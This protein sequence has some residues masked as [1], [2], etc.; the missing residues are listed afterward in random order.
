MNDE[1]PIEKLL[2]R[3]AKKRSDEAGPPPELHPATRRL[4]QGEVARQFPKSAPTKWS[5]LLE[6]WLL[7][8]QR[9]VYGVVAFAVVWVAAVALVPMFSKSKPQASLALNS[10]AS[11]R[12]DLELAK[13]SPPASE[14][15]A[16]PLVALDAERGRVRT[17]S[18]GGAV[19]NVSA[20]ATASPAPAAAT[21]LADWKI[22]T[23]IRRDTKDASVTF[24]DA[25]DASGVGRA[26]TQVANKPGATL[27]GEIS[28]G[29]S[30][31]TPA[32]AALGAQPTRY[33]ESDKLADSSKNATALTPDF[34]FK[35]ERAMITN[36]LGSRL[37]EFDAPKLVV[38]ESSLATP[39]ESA[40]DGFATKSGL[41]AAGEVEG[42]RATFN[43]QAYANLG[44]EQSPAKKKEAQ[45]IW[46]AAQVLANFKIEQAGRDL[47]VVDGDGSVYNGVV[48][49]ENT[50][51][52]QIVAQQN[53][54]LSNSY[55]NKFKFPT[56][57]AANAPAAANQL[58]QDFYRYRVEGTNRTLNQNVV[59]TWNFIDTNALANGNLN[60][61]AAVQ[62]LDAA[63]L[64]SQFPALLQN[65]FINGRAQF[66]PGRE[67]EVNAV[68]AKP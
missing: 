59:F 17:K 58:S 22:A 39:A 31:T 9:W 45:T 62:K 41:A 5:A 18:D 10:P 35:A 49:E 68:P 12:L 37:N 67:F 56:P 19:D 13:Q 24:A 16:A 32:S 6:W 7:L 51:Y 65:S 64:P 28:Q 40:A 47:R 34:G 66:G 53:Q 36:A 14:P 21:A 60:Y 20:P 30:R 43:S 2:R 11:S 1:R 50:V 8:K 46:A 61:N 4:L 52:R 33:F 23:S 26:V 15:V 3:A 44:R 48:D 54:K 57:K 42:N 55:E 29:F 27:A 38:A 63:K 25:T